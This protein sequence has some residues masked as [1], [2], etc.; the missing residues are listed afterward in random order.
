MTMG[1]IFQV[2]TTNDALAQCQKACI[3][4]EKCNGFVKYTVSEYGDMVFT[5]QC[6]IFAQYQQSI[7]R[8][9]RARRVLGSLVEHTFENY[10]KAKNLKAF[11]MAK[12]YVE[13]R[14]W[15]QG[16]WLILYGGYGTGKT[17]LLSAIIQEAIMSGAQATFANLAKIS[18]LEFE[19][20]KSGLAQL[21][22]YDLIGLDDFGVE[23]SQN[24]LTPHVFKLFDDLNENRKGLV[25]TTNMP[26]KG[27]QELLGERISDRITERAIAIE[28]TGE[29]MRKSLRKANISWAEG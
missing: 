22:E 19:K 29:S 2:S 18:T 20:A 11:E 4:P 9:E 10:D 17:H 27:L 1:R 26:L 25:M 5:I 7:Q 21:T 24:W 3:G 6:P 12:K 8:K 23:S 16:G 15:K 13:R 28:L 14:A